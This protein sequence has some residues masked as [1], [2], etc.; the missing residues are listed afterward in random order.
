M[1]QRTAGRSDEVNP[2]RLVWPEPIVV[3]VH[4]EAVTALGFGQDDEGSYLITDGD[5]RFRLSPYALQISDR[6]MVN[7]ECMN[8]T[9]A[10]LMKP[11]RWY[12]ARMTEDYLHPTHP[13]HRPKGMELQVDGRP[14]L[15]RY[16]YQQTRETW[17]VSPVMWR[18][19]TTNGQC[20]LGRTTQGEF[21]GW[22]PVRSVEILSEA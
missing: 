21:I 22:I 5:S 12:V 6:I 19:F 10:Q 15:A 7:M 3:Q 4:G 8:F 18:S 17:E 2:W 16:T 20:F 1:V 13:E 11:K 9:H 14:V